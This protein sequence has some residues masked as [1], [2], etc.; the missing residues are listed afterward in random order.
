MLARQQ[1]TQKM[2]Y[3]RKTCLPVLQQLA[4]LPFDRFTTDPIAIGA[5]KYYLQTAVDAIL[6][7][8]SHILS[9]QELGTFENHATT[10]EVLVKNGI[11]Q[12]EHL[13]TYRQMLGLRNRLG[14]FYTSVD[15]P[16]LYDIIVQ[17]LGDFDPFLADVTRLLDA[18]ETPRNS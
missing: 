9:G 1:L 16:I 4:R 18:A 3:I 17:A 6:D 7:I 10:F 2:D 12:Q 8:A 15:P 14:H 11:L 5:A 13:E